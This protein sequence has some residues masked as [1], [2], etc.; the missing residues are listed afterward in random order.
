MNSQPAETQPEADAPADAPANVEPL[1]AC[2]LEPGT[3]HEDPLDVDMDDDTNAE[4]LPEA[5]DIRASPKGSVHDIEDRHLS[6]EEV[7]QIQ[8]PRSS[9]P[10]EQHDEDENES[11]AAEAY[12][13]RSSPLAHLHN[14]DSDADSEDDQLPNSSI[15]ESEDEDDDDNEVLG[16]LQLEDGGESEE[17]DQLDQEEIGQEE[18]EESLKPEEEEEEE[19]S[20]KPEEE[21]EGLMVKEEEEEESIPR[22][23]SEVI[24]VEGR[25]NVEDQKGHQEAEAKESDGLSSDDAQTRHK[26]RK[27]NGVIWRTKQ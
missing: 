15:E 14:V 7:D 19:Q 2:A 8:E 10:V 25:D 21:E 4:H 9:P 5:I 24:E 23:G 17:E 26:L 27:F 11:D 3:T 22:E 20:M 16:A 18:E 1:E 13:T 6:P 12:E